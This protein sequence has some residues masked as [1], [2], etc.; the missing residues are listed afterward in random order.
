MHREFGIINSYTLEISFCGPTQGH[1]KDT[2]FSQKLLKVRS[3]SHLTASR[4]T[5]LATW[6]SILLQDTGKNF[7]KALVKFSEPTVYRDALREVEERI[8]GN[9]NPIPKSNY[10]MQL[11][12]HEKQLGGAQSTGAALSTQMILM[13][14]LSQKARVLQDSM[15]NSNNNGGLI[16]GVANG[17]ESRHSQVK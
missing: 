8:N 15:K 13:G 9:L 4:E 2:H 1:H 3:T 11:D 7:I 5:Y 17:I 14:G 10:S 16:S 6:F 12:P